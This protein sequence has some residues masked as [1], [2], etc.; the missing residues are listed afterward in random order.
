MLVCV[1]CGMKD[2]NVT[3]DHFGR[4]VVQYFSCKMFVHMTPKM[5]LRLLYEKG[6][7]YQ[8]LSPGAKVEHGK[9]KAATCISTFVCKNKD[10]TK[11]P[12]K[13][14]V[15]CCEEHKSNA[16]NS[17]LLEEY[18]KSIV[19]SIK[20]TLPNFSKKIKL[21]FHCDNLNKVYKSHSAS[22]YNYGEV[23]DSSVYI[24]QTIQV[25]NRKLNIFF[26]S[27]CGDLVCR[28]EAISDL[29]EIGKASLLVPGPI[30]LGG[31]GDVKTESQHGTYRVD[32]P[33]YNGKSAAMRGICLNKITAKFPMYPLRTQV[34]KDIVYN[35][36]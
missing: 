20:S 4:Q 32:I 8:Y 5:R 18:K 7:C 31:V 36:T 1:L 34:Q 24:L 28:K 3:T 12:R 15:L 22:E 21:N 23:M 35:Y 27:G 6:L 19:F 14:H 17:S 2:H 29:E 10:H 33:L 9:H 13:K 25:E 11:Y 16:E 26:D 30:V